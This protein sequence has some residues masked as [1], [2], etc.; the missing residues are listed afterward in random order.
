MANQRVAEFLQ[1]IP[2]GAPSRVSTSITTAFEMVE[3]AREKVA[4]ILADG[5]LSRTGRDA[6]IAEVMAAGPLK[7]MD[8]LRAGIER[9][10]ASIKSER[11]AMR[12]RVVEASTFPEVRKIE[13]RQWL[14]DLDWPGTNLTSRIRRKTP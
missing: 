2:K 11:E 13:V 5:R 6:K 8:Q 1:R 9:D 4:A 10:L 14:R 7:H 12:R 3:N